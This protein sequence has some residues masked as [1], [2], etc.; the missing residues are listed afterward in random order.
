V[1]FLTAQETIEPDVRTVIQEVKVKEVITVV[2]E[3]IREERR[4]DGTTVI[5]TDRQTDKRTDSRKEKDVNQVVAMARPDWSVGAYT[6]TRNVV[7]TIDRRIL[8]ELWAG[9][10]ARTQVSP[11]DFEVGVG[12]SYSF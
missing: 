9:I 11:K 1:G 3:R 4:P 7:V 10:Y 12:L 8:G 5:E 2:Q 6:D